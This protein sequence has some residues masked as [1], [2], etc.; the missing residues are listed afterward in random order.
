LLCHCS[1]VQG[2]TARGDCRL[3]SSIINTWSRVRFL[4]TLSAYRTLTPLLDPSTIRFG[5]AN[6][7]VIKN[8]TV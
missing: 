7:H 4:I 6:K 8:L 1:R 3:F 5:W 2:G